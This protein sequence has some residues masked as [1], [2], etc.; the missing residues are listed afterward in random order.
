MATDGVDPSYVKEAILPEFFRNF[1][2]RRTALDHR[3]YRQLVETTEEIG[4]NVGCAEV[5]SRI[6]DDLKDE[7]EPY[8]RMVIETIHKVITNL[9]AA[10]VD[11][12][13]EEQLV[14]GILYAFQ[15]QS[16]DDKSPVL[17]DSFGTVVNAL[18]VRIKPFLPQSTG[19][20]IFYY[21][22]FLIL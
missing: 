7:S 4:N 20:L 2:V 6:V 9:G 17:L 5:V 21:G 1:W 19:Y 12:K 8:R 22:C 14:D 16:G 15:E 18:G 10:D 13:L 11:R 3:N